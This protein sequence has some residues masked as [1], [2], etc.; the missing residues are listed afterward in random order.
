M[1]E[2][3][4]RERELER[5]GFHQRRLDSGPFEVAAGELEL[6]RLDVDARQADTRELLSEHRQDRAH[7]AAD[8]EQARAGLELCAVADQP[9]APVLSLLHEPLLLGRSVSVHVVGHGSLDD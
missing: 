1:V 4:V 9:V 7:A 2:R 3:L 5:I 8:L 6:L